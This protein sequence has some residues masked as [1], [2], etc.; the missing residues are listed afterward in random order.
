MIIP[1][2]PWISSQNPNAGYGERLTENIVTTEG[3]SILDHLLRLNSFNIFV[4]FLVLF[5]M[6]VIIPFYSI[7]GEDAAKNQEEFLVVP[8]P[9][10][11]EDKL[12]IL[13]SYGEH[14]VAVRMIRT[15]P[16]KVLFE[17]NFSFLRC[18]TW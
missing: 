17:K 5:S 6:I 1:M 3:N 15:N 4:L 18:P 11:S 2:K 13:R 9:L 14:F 16:E 12:A 8:S 10:S 7:A